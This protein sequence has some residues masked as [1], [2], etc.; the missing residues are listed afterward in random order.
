M[1]HASFYK[2]RNNKT[3][4]DLNECE[5]TITEYNS[6][7]LH[8]PN[9]VNQSNEMII[10]SSMMNQT[11]FVDPN[12]SQQYNVNNSLQTIPCTSNMRPLV[13]N[14]GYFP[15]FPFIPHV[16]NSNVN[17]NRNFVRGF[18]PQSQMSNLFIPNVLQSNAY[19]PFTPINTNNCLQNFL[20]PNQRPMDSSS[21]TSF[22]V[23]SLMNE[24]PGMNADEMGT[25][26]VQVC[27][28]QPNESGA[29]E[30]NKNNNQHFHVGRRKQENRRNRCS[31]YFN[32]I[33]PYF[34]KGICNRGRHCR[35]IHPVEEKTN[36]ENKNEKV[37]SAESIPENQENEKKEENN[38]PTT[39]EPQSIQDTYKTR[40]CIYF[41][42]NGSCRLGDTCRFAHGEHEL[43][44][45]NKKKK[46]KKN[47]KKKKKKDEVTSTNSGQE[48]CQNTEESNKTGKAE[49]EVN[50]GETEGEHKTDLIE[51][52]HRK[53]WDMQS[54]NENHQT[55][56][57]R[58]KKEYIEN[59]MERD[60]F[61]N[62]HKYQTNRNYKYGNYKGGN[63][64]RMNGNS[65]SKSYNN[66]G[67]IPNKERI[68][69]NEAKK[70][71]SSKTE[72]STSDTYTEVKCMSGNFEKY[73]KNNHRN[74]MY[75]N[76]VNT[77]STSYDRGSSEH[78]E[79]VIK[80]NMPFDNPNYKTSHRNMC[81][82]Y[83]CRHKSGN[84]NQRTNG[85]HRVPMMPFINSDRRELHNNKINHGM[86][87]YV[88]YRHNEKTFPNNFQPP[89]SRNQNSLPLNSMH[90]M[91]GPLPS[92]HPTYF[93]QNQEN[94]QNE[95]SQ[96]VLNSQDNK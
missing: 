30:K 81:Y 50:I 94:G 95:N 15:M 11:Q 6:N 34:L 78:S 62:T 38:E 43:R 23:P 89:S 55:S 93:V 8:T 79:R 4:I 17:V 22:S 16:M 77:G 91:N 36:Q 41:L 28:E 10:S 20:F 82:C 52:S 54:P 90:T 87:R 27:S 9:E 74:S 59:R 64:Y 47:K 40:M 26:N 88:N 85:F 66:R 29:G 18:L 53:N 60:Q 25:S 1:E 57:V 2:N 35:F 19:H 24:Q 37:L 51:T 14:L 68:E 96:N 12:H 73:E 92:P 58:E 65:W 49:K 39:T 45:K 13:S 63:T 7:N 48:T 21:G 56:F 84:H 75:P 72:Y 76:N 44:K 61:K 70:I 3:T 71:I 67:F 31:N 42:L 5:N 46:K 80:Q 86:N 33:C 69:K 32:R 83:H